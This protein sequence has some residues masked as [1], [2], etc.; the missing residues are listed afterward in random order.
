MSLCA[1]LNHY[2][3]ITI[4]QI[5]TTLLMLS[6]IWNL[7]FWC[8][9]HTRFHIKDMMICEMNCMWQLDDEYSCCIEPQNPINVCK[10]ID[11][12]RSS[13]TSATREG[14]LIKNCNKLLDANLSQGRIS[15]LDSMYKCTKSRTT[16]TVVMT[17]A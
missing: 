17:R 12:N 1:N 9:R 16:W 14:T 10:E 5:F 8:L 15:P 2:T 7:S 13:A 6:K 4:G 3:I 11:G